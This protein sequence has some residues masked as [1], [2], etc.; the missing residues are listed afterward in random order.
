ML[1]IDYDASGESTRI[2][3]GGMLFVLFF[4]F[5]FLCWAFLAPIS[6]AVVAEGVTRVE[7]KRK[8][9]QH[10]EGGVVKKILVY[11]GQSVKEGQLLLVLEDA[12]VRSSLVIIQDQLWSEMAREARLVAQK[13]FQDSVRFPDE[14]SL[15]PSGKVKDM[16]EHERSLFLAGK[17]SLDDE[18]AII[19]DEIR[20]AMDEAKGVEEQIKAATEAIALKGERV[21]SGEV[22]ASRQFLEK[23]QFLQLKEEY[24]DAVRGLSALKSNL[25]ALRQRQSELELRII[26]LRNDYAKSSDDQLKDTKKLIYEAREKIQPAKLSLDRFMITSPMAGQVIDLKVTTVGGVVKPGEP[27]MDVVPKQHALVVEVKIPNR[28]IAKVHAGQPVDIELL[29]Y[30]RDV[31]HIAG[32]LAYLSEDALEDQAQPNTFFYLAH[33]TVSGAELARVPEVHLSAGMPVTAYIQT[34]PHT[35]VDLIMKPFER[36]VA[37]GLRRETL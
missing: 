7:S 18:T 28:E 37:R 21:R 30:G 23:N 15:N 8:T 4:V 11:E 13:K 20:Q 5:G 2:V 12:D 27:L 24:A 14:L 16:L 35:F 25:A 17:K 34:Q 19:K 29:S 3:R 9:I 36:G 1:S 22:L 31:P 10:F 6:G 33:V 32:S 26:G